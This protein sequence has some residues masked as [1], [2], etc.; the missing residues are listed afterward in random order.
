MGGHSL[1]PGLDVLFF[2]CPAYYS[3]SWKNVVSELMRDR[4][5][6]P[7]RLTNGVANRYNAFWLVRSSNQSTFKTDGRNLSYYQSNL[8]CKIVEIDAISDAESL[9]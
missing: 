5:S 7:T 1:A 6:P 4:K 2:T 3:M 9:T 8:T